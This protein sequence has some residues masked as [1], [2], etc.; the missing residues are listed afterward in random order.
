ME[1]DEASECEH[2]HVRKE[3][4]EKERRG[5]GEKNRSGTKK[6]ETKEM[7]KSS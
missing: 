1:E 5:K 3:G 6:E 7:E 4:E 2:M